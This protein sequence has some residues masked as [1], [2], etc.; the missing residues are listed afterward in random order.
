VTNEPGE[1]RIAAADGE[2]E[3]PAAPHRPRPTELA[4]SYNSCASLKRDLAAA[5]I[6]FVEP[7]QRR[8]AEIRS[9]GGLD[10]VLREG[11]ERARE[12]TAPTVDRA[13]RAIGLAPAA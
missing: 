2:P 5:V 1:A 4:E 9:D 3:A 13:R 12:I 10:V 11:A 8:Y 6:D 7:V